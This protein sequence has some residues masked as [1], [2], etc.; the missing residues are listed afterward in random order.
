[1]NSCLLYQIVGGLNSAGSLSHDF[2]STFNR[3]WNF[4]WFR[5]SFYY[6]ME[7]E[8][9]AGQ[10]KAAFLS[11]PLHS[12]KKQ[13]SGDFPGM[14]GLKNDFVASVEKVIHI[15]QRLRFLLFPNTYFSN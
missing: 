6:S 13:L 14:T 1:M 12:P 15:S 11:L 10:P 3:E 5:T 9:K 2:N 7:G 8:V 4:S